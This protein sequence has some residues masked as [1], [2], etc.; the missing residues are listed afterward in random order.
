MGDE[1]SY[2]SGWN[3]HLW[4]MS[5]ELHKNYYQIIILH[6]LISV[7]GPCGELKHII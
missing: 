7:P 2:L 5:P 4:D 3:R 6:L 1:T